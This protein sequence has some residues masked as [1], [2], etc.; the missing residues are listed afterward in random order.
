MSSKKKTEILVEKISYITQK[1]PELTDNDNK[2]IY[3]ILV[4]S[5]LS[6]NKIHEKGNGLQIKFKDIT[7]EAID[8]IYSFISKKIK[9]KTDELNLMMNEN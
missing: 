3:R 1:V 8:D 9:T 7:E 5:G 4:N 6:D 2:E